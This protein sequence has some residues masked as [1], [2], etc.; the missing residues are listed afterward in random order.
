[1]RRRFSSR[2]KVSGLGPVAS[3]PDDGDSVESLLRA[4]DTAMYQAKEKGRNNFQ[5]YSE[6]LNRV[7]IKRNELERRVR[8]AL[9]NNE[10]FLQYQPE[11]DLP[12]GK[13]R[14][15]R[16]LRLTPTTGLPF[17][18]ASRAT[19]PLTFSNS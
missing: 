10:F 18:L 3:Y 4:A 5:F 1:M 6:D 9:A 7:T 14:R 12:T 19:V 2:A 16:A 17:C 8:D 15:S 11:I 13:V